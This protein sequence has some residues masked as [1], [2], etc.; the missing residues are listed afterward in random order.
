MQEEKR[1]ELGRLAGGQGRGGLWGQANKVRL[2][3]SPESSGELW[4]GF[5]RENSPADT[6]L[7]KRGDIQTQELKVSQGDGLVIEEAD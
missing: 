3:V 7:G 2:F 5:H 6:C 1:K 4:E